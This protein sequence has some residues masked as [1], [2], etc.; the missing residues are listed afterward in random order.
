MKS[1]TIGFCVLL[2]LAARPCLAQFQYQYDNTDDSHHP[3]PDTAAGFHAH[4]YLA[5]GIGFVVPS[6]ELPLIIPHWELTGGMSFLGRFEFVYRYE[7]SILADPYDYQS[8]T[9]SSTVE[10]NSLALRYYFLNNFFA[11]AGAGYALGTTDSATNDALNQKFGEAT[12]ATPV[13]HAGAGYSNQLIYFEFRE[14]VGTSRI[15]AYGR[16]S[17]TFMEGVFGFGLYFRS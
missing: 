5:A 14:Y 8:L 4:A 2:V 10:I 9:Y 15:E 7:H 16:N 11:S 17:V 3:F 13:I 12:F 1:I 6:R